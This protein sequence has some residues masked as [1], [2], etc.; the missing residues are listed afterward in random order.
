MINDRLYLMRDLL[1]PTGAV[2]VHCDSR[3]NFLLRAMLDEVFGG[4]NL[5]NENHLVL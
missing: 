5:R 1:A 2:Y 3:V 4:E